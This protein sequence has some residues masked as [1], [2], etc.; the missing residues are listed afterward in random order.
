[1]IEPTKRTV[2]WAFGGSIAFGAV[3]GWPALAFGSLT[4][5]VLETIERDT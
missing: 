5:G 2:L 3:G 4:G 1:M